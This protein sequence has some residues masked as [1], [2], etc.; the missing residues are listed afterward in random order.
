[1]DHLVESNRG[2]KAILCNRKGT[3]KESIAYDME[4]D[5]DL[6]VKIT[7][8]QKCYNEKI[9]ALNGVTAHLKK[10]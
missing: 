8:L 7:N 5:E 2:Y 10:G 1:M 4:E 9:Y 6:L 3:R